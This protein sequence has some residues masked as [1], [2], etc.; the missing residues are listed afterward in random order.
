MNPLLLSFALL[1]A[2]Q[3]TGLVVPSESPPPAVAPSQ[4]TIPPVSLVP[5]IDNLSLLGSV[6]T[7]NDGLMFP[8]DTEPGP[9]TRR[10]R[11]VRYS[12]LYYT[13]LT[14]HKYASYLTV[15]L[16][17]AEYVI[18]QQ[19]YN[20]SGNGGNRGLHGALAAGIAGLF[21]VNTVTGGWNLI[22]SRHEKK[23][24]PRRWVHSLLMMTADAGF[25]VTGA[26]A[27]DDDGGGGA[28]RSTHRAVAIGSMGVALISYGMMWLWKD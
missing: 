28:G 18:G 11:A 16:F 14:I 24:R 26:T 6:V 10:S 3:D 17:A 20:K 25:V 15:P 19:L 8:I 13:R 1:A 2:P 5:R 22:E 21:A 27:P 9:G 7:A 23:G 12:D 4:V